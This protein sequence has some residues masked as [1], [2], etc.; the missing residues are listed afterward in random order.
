M[1]KPGLIFRVV[2]SDDS[3]SPSGLSFEIEDATAETVFGWDSIEA[4]GFDENGP[5]GATYWR[6]IIRADQRLH[7][8]TFAL[9][10]AD[11]LKIWEAREMK[12]FD[13]ELGAAAVCVE[14]EIS[15]KYP[16]PIG[17]LA[18]QMEIWGKEPG[19]EKLSE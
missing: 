5:L 16:E 6:T 18:V 9:G 3:S 15:D 11:F 1:A 17:E 14:V 2:V 13:H 19:H 8:S 4:E 10:D 12:H 7:V